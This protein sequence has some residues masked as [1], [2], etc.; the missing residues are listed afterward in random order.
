MKKLSKDDLK[1]REEVTG[2]LKTAFDELTEAVSRYNDIMATEWATV[3]E[4]QN[5]YNE[6][7]SAAGAWCEGIV[8]QIDDYVS[9]KSEKWQEGEK[10][11]AYEN[12]K[13][14]YDDVDCSESE[15]S[16][17]DELS[18]EVENPAESIEGLPEEVES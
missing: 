7:V 13:S 12:W 15:L 9:D 18:V 14:A 6:A 1:A 4:A 16:Q 3:E 5:N 17:P 10:A 8:S 2:K 11:E